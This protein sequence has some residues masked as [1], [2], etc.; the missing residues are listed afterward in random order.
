M[1]IVG[2]KKMKMNIY[3]DCSPSSTS[4]SSSSSSSNHVEQMPFLLFLR[5]HIRAKPARN[6]QDNVGESN[7]IGENKINTRWF[8]LLGKCSVGNSDDGYLEIEDADCFWSMTFLFLLLLLLLLLLLFLLLASFSI[9]RFLSTST[10]LARLHHCVIINQEFVL[11]FF[12]QSL[13][14]ERSSKQGGWNLLLVDGILI[15][16]NWFEWMN[17]NRGYVSK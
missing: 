5:L 7:S 16:G 6:Y 8:Q 4:S 13:K 9:L 3:T 15:V 10:V 12:P 11:Y 17:W 1:D 2:M 14:D